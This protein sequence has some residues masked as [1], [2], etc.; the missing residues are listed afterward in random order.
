MTGH[1]SLVAY[2][3]HSTV[4][5]HAVLPGGPLSA[6]YSQSTLLYSVWTGRVLFVITNVV[7]SDWKVKL[8]DGVVMMGQNIS[9]STIR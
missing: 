8:I 3:A 5:G 9:C 4:I 7:R 2:A 1:N 6:D